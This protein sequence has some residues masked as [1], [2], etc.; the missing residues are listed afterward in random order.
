MINLKVWVWATGLRVGGRPD[1]PSLTS[2]LHCLRIF[3]SRNKVWRIM[4]MPVIRPAYDWSAWVKI[5]QLK[6]RFD[7]DTYMMIIVSSPKSLGQ[8]HLA[9]LN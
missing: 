3:A 9:K 7:S 2:Q 8:V 6:L 1:N 4:I 5:C